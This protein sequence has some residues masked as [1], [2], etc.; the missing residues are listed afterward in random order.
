MC[1]LEPQHSLKLCTKIP[2][3]GYP[4]NIEKGMLSYE[5]RHPVLM[6][7]FK[8][9]IRCINQ[10]G[11]ASAGNCLPLMG[12][13]VPFPS[14][15]DSHFV[16][17][18]SYQGCPLNTENVIIYYKER[19]ALLMMCFKPFTSCI[20]QMGEASHIICLP[21]VGHDAIFHQGQCL[22]G[23]QNTQICEPSQYGK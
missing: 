3:L 17:K 16:P 6:E 21:L 14:S 18:L 8:T 22:N 9:S 1:H 11:R 12:H 2:D 4:L 13:V 10:T 7:C 23:T 5:E 15:V 19:Y 20:R